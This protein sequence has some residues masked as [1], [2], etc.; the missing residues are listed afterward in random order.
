MFWVF[1]GLQTRWYHL[2]TGICWLWLMPVAYHW[3][4]IS[5]CG[6]ERLNVV[7]IGNYVL[8][9]LKTALLNND[10]INLPFFL[11]GVITA[12][13]LLSLSC[14]WAISKLWRTVA[15]CMTNPVSSRERRN[16][17]DG[18][19]LPDLKLQYKWQK[20]HHTVHQDDSFQGTFL[21]TE[22]I[23]EKK[24]TTI[25]LFPAHLQ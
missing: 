6:K 23:L 24:N 5:L 15:I 22:D 21:V 8:S 2:N 10:K 4:T 19:L 1:H 17:R 16:T 13:L 3:S 7:E 14:H 20:S 25:F 9:C 12:V 18:R 11:I